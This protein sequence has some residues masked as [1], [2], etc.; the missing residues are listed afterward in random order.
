MSDH[1]ESWSQ[2][3]FPKHARPTAERS[4]V[5]TITLLAASQRSRLFTPTY[6]GCLHTLWP[7]T[8]QDEGDTCGRN[9]CTGVLQMTNP[10]TDEGCACWRSAPCHICLGTRPNCPDCGWTMQHP[11]E[12]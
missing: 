5:V 6:P 12:A 2:R 10:E 4:P 1:H 8:G 9:G 11:D 3:W 7:A